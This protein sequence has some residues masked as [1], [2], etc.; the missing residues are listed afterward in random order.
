MLM[1]ERTEQKEYV[2]KKMFFSNASRGLLLAAWLTA[3]CRPAHAFARPIRKPAPQN[4]TRIKFRSL[5]DD[6]GII[7]MRQLAGKNWGRLICAE[8]AAV[9]WWLGVGRSRR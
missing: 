5:F 3:Q 6:D 8:H 9:L 7:P 4:K 2:Q 1:E